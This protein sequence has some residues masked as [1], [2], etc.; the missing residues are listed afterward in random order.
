MNKL[1]IAIAAGVAGVSAA[2]ASAVITTFATFSALNTNPNVGLINSGNGSTRAND[3]IFA[4]GTYS[5][6]AG[7]TA[8][9]PGTVQV[10][11][12]FLEAPLAAFVTNV[13][14]A[15]T[16][17][18]TIAKNTPATGTATAGYTQGGLSG[19]F[20]FLSNAPITVTAPNF[21]QHTYAAN[22]NLLSGTFTNGRLSG[23]NSSGSVADSNITPSA[24]VIFTSDFLDFT[25]TVQRDLSYALTS[26]IA[27][28]APRT[29]A[30]KA[31]N[32]FRANMG[33][34]FSSDPAPVING[35]AVVPEPASWALLVV[36]FGLVGFSSR[37]RSRVV[38]A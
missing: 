36:G 2:P 31:L 26:V 20:S 10:R 30:N 6:I 14:A 1:A 18:A 27:G 35:L 24:S 34:Q 28:I 4:T 25:P 37:R 22:S 17:N 11:F 15:F 23:L 16:L 5:K 29:G 7:V 9:R 33:G 38:A 21:V 8:F 12:S 3:A 19:T 32:S 13:S